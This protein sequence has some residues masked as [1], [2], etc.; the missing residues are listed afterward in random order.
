MA[1][2]SPSNHHGI[3]PGADE[4]ACL[5]ESGIGGRE[6]PV[7][8]EIGPIGADLVDEDARVLPVEPLKMVWMVVEIFVPEPVLLGQ[9]DPEG[10]LASSGY[11]RQQNEA[12]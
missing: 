6:A 3:H 1:A 11:P 10:S 9:P 5:G 8:N 7:K 2:R 12:H 4:G